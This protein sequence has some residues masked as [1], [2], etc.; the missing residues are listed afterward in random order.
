MSIFFNFFFE[1]WFLFFLFIFVLSLLLYLEYKSYYYLNC[2]S[3]YNLIKLMNINNVFVYDIRCKDEYDKGHIINSLNIL[4]T[5]V[6][7][8][9]ILKFHSNNVVIVCEDGLKSANCIRINFCN[10]S[11]SV[12]YLKSGIKGW[13]ADGQILIK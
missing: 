11:N 3:T 1:Y 10:S 2:I 7:K 13:I 12:L 5:S 6:L 4:E 9:R 8:D